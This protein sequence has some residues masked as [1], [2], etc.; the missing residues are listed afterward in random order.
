MPTAATAVVSG[1]QSLARALGPSHQPERLSEAVLIPLQ[2]GTERV[3]TSGNFRFQYFPETV[4]S[5]RA[6][7]WQ[8]KEIPG[9]SLPLYQ[10]VS[11]GEHILTFTVQFSCDTDLR[12]NETI[13]QTLRSDG[14]R[15]RNVDI[16]A[17]I[18]W[19]RQFTCPTYGRGGASG[20]Q[21]MQPPKKLLLH[22]PGTGI[23]LLAGV[24]SAAS[25]VLPDS[26][27]SI[28]TQ[29]NVTHQSFFPSG[30]PRLAQVELGFS[31]TAQ[32][33]GGVQFPGAGDVYNQLLKG[34]GP[35]QPYALLS[36]ATPFQGR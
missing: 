33:G 16:R 12:S 17:A 15:E 34:G 13:T 1:L 20:A 3:N 19:L 10:F 21:L 23:G 11:G 22:M 5:T 31:Q 6:P 27:Y 29:C 7:N 2:P 26:Q 25:E 24:P 36:R 9:G 4:S 8:S 32:Y 30:L 35:F 18:A 28:L 14:L